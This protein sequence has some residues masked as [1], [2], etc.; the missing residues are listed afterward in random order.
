MTTELSLQQAFCISG[1]LSPRERRSHAAG[2]AGTV[3]RGNASPRKEADFLL[4]SADEIFRHHP[5]LW[6]GTERAHVAEQVSAALDTLGAAGEIIF[7]DGGSNDGTSA[8]TATRDRRYPAP[9]LVA[10]M[11]GKMAGRASRS[12]MPADG[13]P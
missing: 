13:T 8:R 7:I 5:G 9:W 4:S 6:R 12:G 1:G 11:D 3:G 2:P 10:G